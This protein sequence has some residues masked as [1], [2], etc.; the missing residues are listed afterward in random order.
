MPGRPG[1]TKPQWI[2]TSTKPSSATRGEERNPAQE[3]SGRRV[4]GGVPAHHV[5]GFARAATPDA[6]QAI[7]APSAEANARREQRRRSDEV[8]DGIEADPVGDQLIHIRGE[9][10]V[11]CGR[12]SRLAERREHHHDHKEQQHQ[13]QQRHDPATD[14]R[15]QS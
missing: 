7:H 8:H 1:A 10:E 15:R 13:A 14:Q 6:G 12:D 11:P 9:I 4:Q 2:F 3:Q 5:R